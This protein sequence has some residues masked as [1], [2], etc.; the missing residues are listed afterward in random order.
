MRNVRRSLFTA[1]IFTSLLSAAASSAAAA[2]AKR[3]VNINSADAGQLS[4]LPRVGMS[5]AQRIVDFR[6]QNGPFKR[7][8]DLMLVRGIGEKTFLLIKP[9]VAIAGESTLKEKVHVSRAESG[10]ETKD[11]KPAKAPKDAKDSKEG[12][13]AGEGSR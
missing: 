2:D 6:K 3:T 7:A 10:K 11:A 9:Y 8:E 12:K 1:L 4:F 5:V 13:D